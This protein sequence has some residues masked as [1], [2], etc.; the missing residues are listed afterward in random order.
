MVGCAKATRFSD[1]CSPSCPAPVEPIK[2]ARETLG[3][4]SRTLVGLC[5]KAVCDRRDSHSE[6]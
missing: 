2:L 4:K 3:V 5:L 1:P 6:Q